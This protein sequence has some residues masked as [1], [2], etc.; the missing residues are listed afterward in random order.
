M[1]K[2]VGVVLCLLLLT[3]TAYSWSFYAIGVVSL[4]ESE[5]L[6]K[7]NVKFTASEIAWNFSEE[8]KEISLY[9]NSTWQT[10]MLINS[11]HSFEN[12]RTDEDGN[13]IAILN[14][15]PIEP[16][17]SIEYTVSYRVV[18]KPW[19]IPDINENTA[20]NLTAIPGNL[21]Q[22]YLENS[23]TW[24]TDNTAIRELSETL[25]ENQTNVLVIIE[26]FVRWIWDNIEYGSNEVPLYPN[27]T[28]TQKRGDCDDQAILLVSMC[29]IVGIPAY[30]QIGSIYSPQIENET[31]TGWEGHVESIQNH[32]GWHGWA[33]VYVPP[34]K[35]LPVDLTYIYAFSKNDALNAIKTAAVTSQRVI[36]YMN[37]IQTDYVSKARDYRDFLINNHFYIRTFDE[38]VAVRDVGPFEFLSEWLNTLIRYILVT[39]LVTG[40]IV[41]VFVGLFYA[42]RMKKKEIVVSTAGNSRV[43]CGCKFLW[44]PPHLLR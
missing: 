11:S 28:L 5:F 18:S 14:M 21:S 13:K 27:E 9:M 2:T 31:S 36:Q 44:R 37:I 20:L 3:S 33:M 32:V 35:W 19:S 16:N 43:T 8:E 40:V 17:Q 30:L 38:I 25:A 4:S 23:G 24:M 15:P 1:K 39:L 41:G 34:W 10:V 22:A 7:A 6:I 12:I 42:R 26:N 29:R